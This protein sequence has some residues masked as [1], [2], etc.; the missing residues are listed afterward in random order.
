MGGRVRGGH[1]A[2]RFRLRAVLRDRFVEQ[3]LLVGPGAPAAVDVEA[4][5]VARGIGGSP[6]QG[7]EQVGV[8]LGD[9]RKVGVEDRRVVGEGTVGRAELLGRGRRR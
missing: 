9:T 7:A 5:P 2:G 4:D 1:P 8:E 3:V 6:A